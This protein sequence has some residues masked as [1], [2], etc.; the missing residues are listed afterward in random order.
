MSSRRLTDAGAFA[1]LV[2]IERLP[3]I[4]SHERTHDA[5]DGRHDEA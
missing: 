2:P 4:G 5:Q 3:E 1:G